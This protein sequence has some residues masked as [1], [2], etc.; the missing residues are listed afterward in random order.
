M[1]F[2]IFTLVKI[3]FGQTA[4][5]KNFYELIRTV[6]IYI[7]YRFTASFNKLSVSSGGQIGELNYKRNC[8]VVSNN[9]EMYEVSTSQKERLLLRTIMVASHIF[10]YYRFHSIKFNDKNQC[11]M[12]ICKKVKSF[13]RVFKA[14]HER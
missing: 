2:F 11:I 9:K 13:F 12:N 3:P 4:A 1:D 6:Y 10:N 7:F 5:S 8:I 14:V